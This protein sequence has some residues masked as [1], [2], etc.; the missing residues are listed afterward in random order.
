[1]KTMRLENK[2]ENFYHENKNSIF[3]FIFNII[4]NIFDAKYEEDEGI[5]QY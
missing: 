2:N 4:S 3:I 5:M 1:M